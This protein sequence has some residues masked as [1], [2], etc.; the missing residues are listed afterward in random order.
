[1]VL[2][3]LTAAVVVLMGPPCSA[4][5]L[6]PSTLRA[7]DNYTATVEKRLAQQHA[8][9]DTYLVAPSLEAAGRTDADGQQRSTELRIEPVNGGTR[10]ISGGLLHHWRGTAFA[11]GTKAVPR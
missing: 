10:E 5:R 2:R 7:Y 8:S 6:S 9:R 4:A 1:M 3:V 11:P